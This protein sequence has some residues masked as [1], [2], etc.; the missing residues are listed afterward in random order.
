MHPSAC[1][2]G[3][4]I[5]IFASSLCTRLSS[6]NESTAASTTLPLSGHDLPHVQE[7]VGRPY[8]Y[9][10]GS[11]SSF[12]RVEFSEPRCLGITQIPLLQ[13]VETVPYQRGFS[14]PLCS[15]FEL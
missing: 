9:K 10:Y 5:S 15:S 12:I 2:L 11:T 13:F 4:C 6:K 1:G 14:S 8:G 7:I 3:V